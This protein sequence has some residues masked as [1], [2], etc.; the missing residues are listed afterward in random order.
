VSL[1][2]KYASLDDIRII[3]GY[4][5]NS[6]VYLETNGRY[7]H[8]WRLYK[9]KNTFECIY[10]LIDK[11]KLVLIVDRDGKIFGL[12]IINITMDGKD[13]DDDDSSYN[14]TIL[15]ICYLDCANNYIYSRSVFLILNTLFDHNKNSNVQLF[16]NESFDFSNLF[17]NN[18]GYYDVDTF[19]RF[20]VYCKS[21]NQN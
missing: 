13:D 3:S 14:K 17:V 19:E 6:Q 20:I 7:F 1:N 11:K 12:S 21:L 16:V 4:L 8:E 2:L 5:D 15:Q 9:L 18:A 10:D